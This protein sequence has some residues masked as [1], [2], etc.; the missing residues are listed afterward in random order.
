MNNAASI[1]K[2]EP[3]ELDN[4][5]GWF[6]LVSGFDGPDMQMG[7]FATQ[8]QAEEWIDL[9]RDIWIRAQAERADG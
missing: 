9:V 4:G 6:V 3:R 5:S 1:P 8:A 2:F 7:G